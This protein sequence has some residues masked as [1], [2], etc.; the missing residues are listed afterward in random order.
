MLVYPGFMVPPSLLQLFVPAVMCY[1]PFPRTSRSTADK[2]V[3]LSIP[4]LKQCF[5]PLLINRGVL[6]PQR[7][8]LLIPAD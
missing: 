3:C 7:R 8:L 5:A 2:Q 6:Q 1:D 4:A